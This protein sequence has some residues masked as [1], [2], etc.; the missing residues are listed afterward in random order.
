VK[1]IFPHYN[2]GHFINQ[3]TNPTA[4]EVLRFEEMEEPD[5]AELHK[6]TFYE[7]LWFDA[8]ESRQTID[9]QEYHIL[10]H[11]LFFISPGQ[12]HRFEEWQPL[13]GGTLLFTEEFVTFDRQNTSP[14][15]ELSFLDNHYADPFLR[16][17]TKGFQEIR[18]TIELIVNEKQRADC[19]MTILQSLLH[20]L[21]AQIQRCTDAQNLRATP[22]RPLVLYKQL[23]RLIDQHF[24]EPL[25][26]GD[27]AEKMFVTQHHLNVVA[28]QVTGKTTTELI[29][30]R[31]ILEAKRLLTFSDASVSE[32]ATTLSFF[33]LSYFAKVFK[34]ETGVSPLAF[35]KEMSEK[36][37]NLHASS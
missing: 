22:K 27:Y 31:N 12:L 24:R 14:L 11:T 6:H 25:T 2:I 37:R 21:L 23:K 32:I 1:E 4:F 18:N 26:A 17:D 10:P 30:A 5:V 15:S 34:A 29:R 20:V 36:Y 13:R 3:P 19:A 28:K 16:P 9:Y 7:I 8:G 35:K 33:D